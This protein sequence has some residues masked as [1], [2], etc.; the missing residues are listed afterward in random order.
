[1]TNRPSLPLGDYYQLL[2]RRGLL[3]DKAPLAADLTDE[4]K[5]SR[6]LVDV[7]FSAL[8]AGAIHV[9]EVTG[10]LVYSY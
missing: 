5:K 8:L 6:V 7:K 1:M 3:A 10:S 9:V 4:Q 2:L